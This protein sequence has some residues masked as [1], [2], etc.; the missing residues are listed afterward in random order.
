M[1][2]GKGF[3]LFIGGIVVGGVIGFYSFIFLQF[4]FALQLRG[5]KYEQ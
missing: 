1:K 3:W 4:F 2:I 5:L